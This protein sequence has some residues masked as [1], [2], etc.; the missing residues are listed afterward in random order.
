MK[1][2]W[3]ILLAM[4]LLCACGRDVAPLETSVP[5]EKTV[6]RLAQTVE[7]EKDGIRLRIDAFES[8]TL[9]LRLFNRSGKM[10]YYGE[11]FAVYRRTTEGGWTKMP[12]DRSWTAIAYELEDGDEVWLAC[13]LSEMPM[14]AGTYKLVRDGME[15][16]FRLIR[17]IEEK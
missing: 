11:S 2:I 17:V 5:A 13:D 16:S 10:W 8:G 14:E 4:L 3:F 7:T 12:D 15:L 6:I 9:S 1:K